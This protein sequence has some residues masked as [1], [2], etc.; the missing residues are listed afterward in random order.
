MNV[1]TTEETI[2]DNP[3]GISV[4]QNQDLAERV[5]QRVFYIVGNQNAIQID[6]TN[7]GDVL[8]LITRRF[9]VSKDFRIDLIQQL[10]GVIKE[11][12]FRHSTLPSKLTPYSEEGY[13]YDRVAAAAPNFTSLFHIIQKVRKDVFQMLSQKSEQLPKLLGK[14]FLLIDLN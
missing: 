1:K 3:R 2:L 5:S 9:R 14:D 11:P 13:P 6:L 12:S 7:E 10:I 8:P 4:L